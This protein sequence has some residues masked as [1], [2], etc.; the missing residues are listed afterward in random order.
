M[1]PPVRVG[2]PENTVL[3][4]APVE[5]MVPALLPSIVQLLTLSG[6]VIEL[7]PSPAAIPLVPDRRYG[8]SKVKLSGV[9]PP[10]TLGKFVKVKRLP[11][12]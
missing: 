9:D 11:K 4:E 2:I 5:K 12:G 6:T 7:L 8:P 1:E 3:P 10:I